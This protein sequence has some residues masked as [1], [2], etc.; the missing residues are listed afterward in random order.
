MLHLHYGQ[1][2]LLREGLSLVIVVA[3]LVH[4]LDRRVLDGGWRAG[5]ELHVSQHSVHQLDVL[6]LAGHEVA[7]L[8]VG[9]GDDV[10]VSQQGVHVTA[11]GARGGRGINIL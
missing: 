4:E 6:A 3:G 9:V 2:L 11:G 10:L 8:G 5:L 1:L 7:A